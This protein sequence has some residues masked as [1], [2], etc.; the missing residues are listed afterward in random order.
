[1]FLELCH[2]N[3]KEVRGTM[4]TRKLKTDIIFGAL[5]SEYNEI[6]GSQENFVYIYS[7]FNINRCKNS[8]GLIKKSMFENK[9]KYHK[10]ILEEDYQEYL[11]H[12]TVN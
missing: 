10:D 1:M 11:S 8:K 9:I 4:T 12:I 2:M 3:V 6:S 5:L 7:S